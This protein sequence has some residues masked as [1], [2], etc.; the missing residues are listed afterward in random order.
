[1][2]ILITAGG[3]SEKIDEVRK[4]TNTASGRLGTLIAEEFLKQTE[5]EITYLCSTDALKPKDAEINIHKI[6]SVR[7]LKAA[8]TKLMT[9]NNYNAV[10]H[11]MAVSDYSVQKV[12]S[13]NDLVSSITNT[14]LNEPLINYDS[15]SKAIN[16][17]L[18]HPGKN[19]NS[20]KKISSD[21]ENLIIF[22]DKTQ[23]VIHLIKQIQPQ[24]ILVGFKLL[25]DAGNRDLLQKGYDLLLKNNCDF[26]LAND[27]K[28]INKDNH[29]GIL[30]KPDR[31]Y[32]LLFSKQEIAEAIV[33]NVLSKI[34]G[35]F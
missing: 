8:L 34:R 12:I 6:S 20:L 24:T 9:Q 25:V 21:I 23:K 11:T 3:T 7:E 22:M 2:K 29:E 10:I 14:I 31:S 19:V 30:I 27:L 28:N 35:V 13:A 26:V 32:L 16:T 33:N 1:M 5:A 4:I 18:L 15:L 17:A